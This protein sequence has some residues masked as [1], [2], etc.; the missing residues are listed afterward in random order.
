[1]IN[2]TRHPAKRPVTLALAALLIGAGVVR[3]D[4]DN[5][6]TLAGGTNPSNVSDLLFAQEIAE[7]LMSTN[8]DMVY[9]HVVITDPAAV[10]D[11][12]PRIDP[13]LVGQILN[14]TYDDVKFTYDRLAAQAVLQL[15]W[16]NDGK[17]AL[18]DAD[19][20][21]ILPAEVDLPA[22]PTWSAAAGSGGGQPVLSSFEVPPTEEF[23][24]PT[25]D[26]IPEPATLGLAILGGI[27]LLRRRVKQIHQAPN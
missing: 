18:I 14:G 3:A 27:G 19:E 25:I 9:E 8:N 23:E 6:N 7:L 13:T 26:M 21:M 24:G 1:M 20:A 22:S 10:L 17:V 16:F 2:T 12:T 5:D 15:L 4:V 11:A